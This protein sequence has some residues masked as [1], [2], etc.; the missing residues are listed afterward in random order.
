M[1]KVLAVLLL[2]LGTVTAA[3]AGTNPLCIFLPFLCGPATPPSSP[4]SN[5]NPT[6]APEIDPAS[7][8]SGLM[9]L[10]GGLVV[11]RGRR[12]K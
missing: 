2:S 4:P 1:S 5:G 12:R 10:S 11:L 7:A 9:L 8:I 6:A 3:Q